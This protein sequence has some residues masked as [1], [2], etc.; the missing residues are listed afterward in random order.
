ME[1]QQ[2]E[3]QFCYALVPQNTKFAS[4][5]TEKKINYPLRKK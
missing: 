4:F 2:Q 5:K 3:I 1:K